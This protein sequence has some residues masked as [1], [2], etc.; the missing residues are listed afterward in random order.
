MKKCFPTYAVILFIMVA[1]SPAWSQNNP[2]AITPVK[3]GVMINFSELA[4]KELLNPPK[5]QEERDNEEK[6]DDL[7]GIPTNLP[8]PKDAKVFQLTGNYISGIT[9]GTIESVQTSS[10]PPIKSFNGL[11][12]NNAVIPPDVAGAAGPNHLFENLNSQY[13]V[14]NKTG[15]IISTLT[16]NSFWSGLSGV[17]SPYSDPH[18]VF[19]SASDRWLACIIAN[20]N[21]GDYG[22][23]L[24]CS[25]TNDPTGSWYEYSIDT[26]PS[27]FL[28]DYPLLG[29]NKSWV[30]ITT[31]DFKNLSFLRT[32]IVVYNKKKVTAGTLTS[33]TTFF[34]SSIFTLSPAETLD[35]KQKNEYMLTDY[36]GNSGGAG[37]VQVCTISGKAASPV[38]TRGATIGVTQTWA[39]VSLDAPQLGSTHGINTGGTKMR[40]IMVRNGYIWAT[41]TVYLP[42]ASP[43][44]SSTDFWQI[45]AKTNAVVQY[46]LIDDPTGTLWTSYS[47]LAVTAGNHVL[48]GSTMVGSTIY[49]SAVY[50]YRNAA[51][52]L[53]TFRT[54]YT[55]QA[56]GN[57]YY[58]TFGG[59]RNRWGDFSSTS[60]DPTDGTFW[61]LQEY[62]QPTV[63]KWGTSWAN[64]GTPA[65]PVAAVTTGNEISNDKNIIV[66]P[67]PGQGN[68]TVNYQ[69]GKSGEA[70]ITV[71]RLNGNIVYNKKVSVT[72]GLNHINF[73]IETAG[74]GNYK[75][76]IQNGNEMKQVQFVLSR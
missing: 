39:E 51:D 32:R 68:F 76:V 56:G 8:V 9:S 65:A 23:F 11:L 58:K 73:N 64:V 47:S 27:S 20:L 13:R 10:P 1:A 69:A 55:Y 28:P 5:Q 19:D 43:N 41:H 40:A 30:V 45:N 36:N 34:D 35:P 50:S 53:N 46:G 57:S 12:D 42:A 66:I 7:T 22:I 60:L 37:Y 61:T 72:A 16:L 71:Y 31:N 63:N 3:G 59:T 75:L 4:K 52:A 18:I 44:R 29:Y 48:I 15:G 21:N 6:E 38:Y 33:A 62:A 25:L 2:G 67:N 74:N 26:G 54:S 49:A 24:A 17:G 70:V 14:L